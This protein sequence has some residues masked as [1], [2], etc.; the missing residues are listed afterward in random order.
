MYSIAK[1]SVWI[2]RFIF[3]P[4]SLPTPHL[5]NLFHKHTSVFPSTCTPTVLA[6]VLHTHT[7]THAH[8]RT[9][10]YTPP[11]HANGSLWLE[12]PCSTSLPDKL[13]PNFLGH[14]S[15]FISSAS[16]WPSCAV[17]CLPL[18][19]CQSTQDHNQF[20]LV[21]VII[22]ASTL[23]A[24]GG[25]CQGSPGKFSIWDFHAHTFAKKPEILFLL[26]LREFSFFQ[27]LPV[28]YKCSYLQTSHWPIF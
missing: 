3:C 22:T 4:P 8:S 25:P 2:F 24:S 6:H 26:S 23:R 7:Q 28:N 20:S 5:F 17:T 11:P 27:F 15:L 16:P 21:A 18:S 1:K 10:T 19:V 12:W 9:C 14:S 13:L